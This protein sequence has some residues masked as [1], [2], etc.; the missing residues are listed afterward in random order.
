MIVSKIY[1]EESYLPVIICPYDDVCGKFSSA[2]F[3]AATNETFDKN[4]KMAIT[5][6]TIGMVFINILTSVIVAFIITKSIRNRYESI[7]MILIVN[8][9]A[10]CSVTIEIRNQRQLSA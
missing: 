4:K 1:I 9:L 5:N 8:C 2:V 7:E 3:M 6:E 10:D